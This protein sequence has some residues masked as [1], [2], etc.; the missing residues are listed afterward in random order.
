[1]SSSGPSE[2]PPEPPEEPA[3][4]WTIIGVI[5]IVFLCFT[6]IPAMI[7]FMDR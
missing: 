5:L 1:V 6:I 3:I 2:T 4:S 7:F